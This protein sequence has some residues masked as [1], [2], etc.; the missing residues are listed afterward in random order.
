MLAMKRMIKERKAASGCSEIAQPNT[1]VLIGAMIV[2]PIGRKINCQLNTS[3]HFQL[4]L[5][6]AL[7]IIIIK[8]LIISQ[9]K[10]GS[11][12]LLNSETHKK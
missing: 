1:S 12:F 3:F 7:H 11:E 2:E 9:L 8:L 5:N 6:S 4:C 10:I